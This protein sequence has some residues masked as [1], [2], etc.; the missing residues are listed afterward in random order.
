VLLMAERATPTATQDPVAQI[1][2]QQADG[3][4]KL[5]DLWLF[6]GSVCNLRCLHC[7]TGSSPENRTLEPLSRAETA[8]VLAEAA[9][10]GTSQIYLTGGEPFLHPDIAGVLA[11]CLAVAPTTVLTNATEPLAQHLETLRALHAAHGERL[12]LRVSLDSYE[13]ARHDA[14]RRDGAGRPRNAFDATTA[15]VEQ[16]A[17]IGFRPIITLSAEV[18]RG[19]PVAPAIVERKTTALF[20]ARGVD[21]EVKILPATLDQGTQQARRDQAPIAPRATEAYLRMT[22]TRREQLMCHNSRLVAKHD[23]ALVVYPCPVLVPD[24]PAAVGSMRRFALG[25]S[26]AAS[27]ERGVGLDHPSCATYCCNAKGVC[28]NG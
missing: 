24:G 12:Q 26:L 3:A 25:T 16:L 4:P 17:A 15:N 21:V 11:D 18:Y 7:Y 10:L 27:V 8:A 13:A 2:F 5:D 1:A 19:N 14:I 28:G 20:R 22:N 9:A 6:T 23:G